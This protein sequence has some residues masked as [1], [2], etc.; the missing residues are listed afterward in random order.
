MPRFTQ[1]LMYNVIAH[2]PPVFDKYAKKLIDEG[3]VTSE[4][5]ENIKKEAFAYYN[6]QYEA[7]KKVQETIKQ[8]KSLPG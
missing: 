1:P 8:K 3:V 6:E 4:F 2:H 5:A 7:S